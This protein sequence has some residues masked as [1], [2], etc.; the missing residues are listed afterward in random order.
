MIK[1]LLNGTEVMK[2]ICG[3][4]QL[5][6]HTLEKTTQYEQCSRED[7]TVRW[8]WEIIHE[9]DDELKRKFLKF[10]TGS[11]RS[12]LR[13][14]GELNMIIMIQGLDDARLP[15]AHTCFN[16]LILPQYSSKDHLKAKL[17]KAI[18]NHEGF[19]LM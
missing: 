5:D 6:F 16:H 13:G 12:P 17:L 7:K 3:V 2:L 10:T 14:L 1:Q 18:D 4:D 9:L 19:G 15:S 11:D 8:F